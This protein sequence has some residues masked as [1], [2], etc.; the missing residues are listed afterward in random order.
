MSPA[1]SFILGILL[2]TAAESPQLGG[3]NLADATDSPACPIREIVW[4][5]T[6]DTAATATFTHRLSASRRSSADRTRERREDGVP[7]GSAAI[8]VNLG[9][10]TAQEFLSTVRWSPVTANVAFQ[11]LEK[12]AEGVSSQDRQHLA[13][14]APSDSSAGGDSG[15]LKETA[16][17]LLVNWSVSNG[18][19]AG[20]LVS[21]RRSALPWQ[22]DCYRIE[23]PANAVETECMLT[24][25][26]SLKNPTPCAWEGTTIK[27]LDKKDKLFGTVGNATLAAQGAGLF[28]LSQPA[29]SEKAVVTELFVF[30]LNKQ[31]LDKITTGQALAQ[32][33]VAVTLPTDLPKGALIVHRAGSNTTLVEGTLNDESRTGALWPSGG[34]L[35]ANKAVHLLP[36]HRSG[37]LVVTRSSASQAVPV[38]LNEIRN[39]V[40]SFR[41]RRATEYEIDPGAVLG[42]SLCLFRPTIEAGLSFVEPDFMGTR[43][44]EHPESPYTVSFTEESGRRV[45]APA[46]QK[47]DLLAL[48]DDIESR[49]GAAV[50]QQ[51][52]TQHDRIQASRDALD[53]LKDQLRA[54]EAGWRKL[55]P[56]GDA[57]PGAVLTLAAQIE[58]VK[59]KITAKNEEIDLNS[60]HLNEYIRK[61]TPP[62]T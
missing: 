52:L 18:N 46:M 35:T 36:I 26:V 44:T 56:E 10:A 45:K 54:L 22:I 29:S 47:G 50:F 19:P 2:W 20:L 49:L 32:P 28:E 11:L 15:A 43:P 25:W 23:L 14:P 9:D 30:D 31:M 34:S 16:A 42:P 27:L 6:S 12:T 53:G 13:A 58:A 8:V 1:A 40:L 59:R 7:Q 48:R 38:R 37:T 57:R 61:N 60:R 5:N 51:I 41:V 4:Q 39:G 3:G 33:S 24:T 17:T 55:T 21:Y 62:A